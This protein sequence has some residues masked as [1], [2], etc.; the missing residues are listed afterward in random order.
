MLRSMFWAFFLFVPPFFFISP[1]FSVNFS[2]K[3]FCSFCS[4]TERNAPAADTPQ[5][6]N[7]LDS[8]TQLRH[9]TTSPTRN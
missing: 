4:Q 3:V 7:T 9:Q 2:I 6:S 5:P 8:Y 1:Y